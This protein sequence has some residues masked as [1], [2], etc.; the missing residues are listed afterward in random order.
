MVIA[1]TPSLMYS[2]NVQVAA[3][4]D[5]KPSLAWSAIGHVT[6]LK[7]LGLQFTET[8]ELK[9]VKYRLY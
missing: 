3:H 4:T 5:D 9:V 2:L 1:K 6:R 8:A 7:L